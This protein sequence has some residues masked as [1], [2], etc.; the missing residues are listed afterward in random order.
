MDIPFEIHFETNIS[1]KFF[2]PHVSQVHIIM[3]P[4]IEPI[5]SKRPLVLYRCVL[6][7]WESFFVVGGCFSIAL[8]RISALSYLQQL[9]NSNYCLYRIRL[10]IEFLCILESPCAAWKRPGQKK[11]NCTQ[12]II[13]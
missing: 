3:L 11:S 10:L 2:S 4:K 6:I 9:F 8:F 1:I 5:E 13:N 12:K 7:L